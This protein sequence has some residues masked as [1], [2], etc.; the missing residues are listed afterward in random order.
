MLLRPSSRLAAERSF[1]DLALFGSVARGQSGMDSDVD[2]LE[3]PPQ[4]E[5]ISDVAA[6]RRLF[7]CVLDRTVGVVTYGGLQAGLDDDVLRDAVFL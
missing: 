5:T 3:S 4:G 6:L 1:G 7:E 2:R